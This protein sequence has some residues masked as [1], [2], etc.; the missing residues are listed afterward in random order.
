MINFAHN[1]PVAGSIAHLLIPLLQH[2][3]ARPV[4]EI[5]VQAGLTQTPCCKR[6]KR[7]EPVCVH[8]CPR[9]LGGPAHRTPALTVFVAIEPQQ[10][11]AAGRLMAQLLRAA[12]LGTGALP[13]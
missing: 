7:M 1:L 4:A 5:A 2:D 9:H 3:P 8:R 12:D 11:E 6:I 13:W 10:P